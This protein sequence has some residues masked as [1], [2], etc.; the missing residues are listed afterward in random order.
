MSDEEA[1]TLDGDLEAIFTSLDGLTIA[2]AAKLVK[3]LEDRWGVSA[4]APAAVAIAAPGAGD[5]AEEAEVQTAFDVILKGAGQQ[6]IQVIKAVRSITG[7]GLK[8]AKAMVDSAPSAVKEGV[9]KEDAAK[10]SKDLADAGAE[11]EVK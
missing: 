10:I 9:S 6:K 4:A 8:E 7:L 5:G 11:V 3:A 2:K 1:I